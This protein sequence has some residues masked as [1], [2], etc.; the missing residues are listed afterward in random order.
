MSIGNLLAM[1]LLSAVLVSCATSRVGERHP[2]AAS[3]AC[4][5]DAASCSL[6]LRKD[7]WAFAGSY[8]IERTDENRFRVHGRFKVD[9]TRMLSAYTHSR[10]IITFYFFDS[11]EI[12]E[13]LKI[14]VRGKANQ[15]SEFSKSLTTDKELDSSV[16]ALSRINVSEAPL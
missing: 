10:V 9:T 8:S 16:F 6:D 4:P 13:E 7:D 12:V 11:D 2:N 14:T 15:F 3:S 1:T 5:L